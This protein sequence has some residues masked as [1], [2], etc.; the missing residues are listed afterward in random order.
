[1]STRLVRMLV[2]G[3]G[4]GACDADGEPDDLQV[5]RDTVAALG[6]SSAQLRLYD[7]LL[8]P[9]NLSGVSL[10]LAPTRVIEQVQTG[11]D[12]AL[13]DRA[14]LKIAS[15]RQTYLDL[16][17][18]KCRYR[19]VY[20]HGRLRIELAAETGDCD[21]EPCVVAT[22]YTTTL[23]DL[24]IGRSQVRG[25]TSVLRVP[26]LKGEARSYTAEVELTD[27][28][29]R[30]LHL[31]Q[32]LTWRRAQGCVTAELGAEFTVDGREISVGAR[33]VEV[34]GGC[35]RAGEVQVAWDDGEALAWEYDG[36]AALV[37]RGPR[38]R[39]FVVEQACGDE[40]P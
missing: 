40:Q 25:A 27:P 28:A 14:C 11:L 29:D 13:A 21:G 19:G 10:A 38:G 17:F 34:C 35:P 4:L 7:G 24:T 8:G 37:V 3:A 36:D 9:V 30:A 6:S 18:R 2:L 31:R 12:E 39:E 5:A 26:E 16:R 22:R 33:A 1:M 23:T 20:V 15:D 32:E